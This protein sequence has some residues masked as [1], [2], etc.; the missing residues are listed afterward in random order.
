MATT[1][2]TSTELF[3]LGS[4]NTALQLPNG[5]T[6]ER[7]TS[8]STGEWRYNTTTNLVEFWDGGE[9][10]D[11][12]SEDIPPT[13]SE[14]FAIVSWTGNGT[15]QTIT[16]VGFQP[17]LVW[18]KEKTGSSYNEWY[19]STRGATKYIS[20]N[21]TA[22]EGTSANGLQSFTVDGFTVGSDGAVNESDNAYEAWCWKANGGTTVTNNE[23]SIQS[24]VQANDKAGFSIIQ[25]TGANSLGAG[26]FGH[27]LS[28]PPT[29][30]IIRDLDGNS[31]WIAWPNVFGD[32][33]KNLQLQST[34]SVFNSDIVNS[35][36]PTSTV[37]S[38]SGSNDVNNNGKR[39][40]CYAFVGKAQYSAISTYT[41][42]GRFQGPIVNTGF[43]PAYIMIKRTDS[44]GNW[45]TFDYTRDPQNPATKILFPNDSTDVQ[46]LQTGD[47]G[48]LNRLSN[49]FQ[50]TDS[51][52]TGTTNFNVNGATYL[53]WAIAKDAST[54]TPTTTGAYKG[55]NYTGTAYGASVLDTIN[56][57]GLSWI[58]A[59][60]QSYDNSI[61]DLTT[62][63]QFRQ[64]SATAATNYYQS[65]GGFL[66]NWGNAAFNIVQG[67]SNADN[68]NASG[69]TYMS[70]NWQAADRPTINT[71]GSLTS[72]VNAN[73]A[74]G[75][76]FVRFEGNETGGDTLGHGL[77]G[78]PEFA[79][80]KQLDG[81]REWT[82][83]LFFDASGTY[84]V[85]SSNAAKTTD[86]A[87]WS[88]VDSTTVTMNV[89]PYTNGTGSPYL[90]Y[91]FR[92][93]TG[94]SKIGSYTGTG[95]DGNAVSTGFEPAFLMVKRM[96][97]T[98]G[99]LVFDNTRNTSNPRN[100]RLE[101][102]NNQ[103]EQTGSASK[104]VDFNASDFEANGSD[105][106]LNASGGTYLYMVFAESPKT[107]T[108]SSAG[109]MSFLC[110]AGGGSGGQNYGGGGGAG[111]LKT[112][113]RRNPTNTP[114]SDIIS[115]AAGTY[116]ITVGGGAANVSTLNTAGLKGSDSS[117]AGPS[118]TTITTTGGGGGGGGSNLLGPTGGSGG[119]SAYGK[120][121]NNPG[122]DGQGHTGGVNPTQ[123]SP[124]TNGGGGGA[125][126][127]GHNGTA[128]NGGSGGSGM[129]I[130]ITGSD[131]TYAGGGGAGY[132]SDNSKTGG[133]GGP[134]GGG[135][136]GR[137]GANDNGTAG[138]ANTGGGGGGT[139]GQ[140]SGSAISGAGGSGVVILRL[141]TSEYTGTTTGSPTVTTS[142]SET[143]LTYTGS[144]TYVHS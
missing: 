83:P 62:G 42:N 21:D 109:N 92:S 72:T 30:L 45:Q 10:R 129:T 47:Y 32:V 6:A 41:G 93:I 40:I 57:S 61:F 123:G 65:G 88:A 37:I 66:Q 34:S 141:L 73:Q 142:G 31:N 11:L 71:D 54:Y 85:L 84:T 18:I 51:A 63:P 94:Y 126:S 29:W 7:P 76:S 80:Y 122:I 46:N 50:I 138:T 75:F 90:A 105:S 132:A 9:W 121:S 4:L 23:G 52:Y 127:P 118:L 117:I 33:T 114:A 124:Y 115:L 43:E 119:G 130:G 44:T 49:G 20:S 144:G 3:D 107:E 48:I 95:S 101:W 12:Q 17:D 60:S 78:T 113:V 143:I 134:G 1:K 96:D 24:T 106:E 133:F 38:I 97:S 2:I 14:H 53:Y 64:D 125:G 68:V 91:F 112:S 22:G 102:N 27:G 16:G 59:M 39:F 8:P 98:G 120:G 137:T 131:V 77:G 82:C 140:N 108:Y 67:A 139:G 13:P 25:Y 135:D 5:T 104:F 74:A 103:A 110:V 19:D 79:I 15:S 99:W 86:T 116:T 28:T 100:N 87:R 136:G 58:K 70:W 89:S 55:I 128:A 36:A 56:T 81:T 111:G 35:T 69:V 26:T